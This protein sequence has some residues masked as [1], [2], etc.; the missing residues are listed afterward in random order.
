MIMSNPN[1]LVLLCHI[2]FVKLTSNYKFFV[3]SDCAPS[4]VYPRPTLNVSS[5]T[6]VTL[7]KPGVIKRQGDDDNVMSFALSYF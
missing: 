7:I 6:M 4:H 1:L 5:Y 3:Y 2:V